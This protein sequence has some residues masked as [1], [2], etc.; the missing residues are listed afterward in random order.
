MFFSFPLYLKRDISVQL[1]ETLERLKIWL[2]RGSMVI[3]ILFLIGFSIV[4]PIDCIAQA[5]QSSNN[6]LNTFI[7]VGALVA[8]GIVCTT[9]VVARILFH[10]SC[11]QDIPRRYIPIAPGDLPHRGSR[12]LIIKNMDKSKELSILFKKPK[13]PV[14]HAG[15]EPPVRC[16]SPETEK[17]F[18]EYLNYKVCIKSLAD[19]LK[20]QGVFL[21]NMD[22][23]MK[24][25]DTFADVVRNQFIKDVNNKVQLENASR[26]IELYEN[27]RFSGEE[28]TREQF[29]E[30]VSLAIY[31]VDI[32]LT[33]DKKLPRLGKL[34]TRSQL[35]FNF[36]DD[37]WDK[38]FSKIPTANSINPIQ[39]MALNDQDSE[40]YYP[41]SAT[42]LKRTNTNSTVARRVSSRVMS[43]GEYDEDREKEKKNASEAPFHKYRSV[44]TI[45]ESRKTVTNK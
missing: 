12:K 28:V 29:T 25:D 1:M 17:L 37:T 13:D 19:R 11:I 39:N 5:S 41:D 4:L 26:F 6:A 22:V 44:N 40:L 27:V 23:D 34:N 45:A 35:Q 36:D 20:Y 14:I 38:E 18:P 15:L 31:F 9:I 32:S 33:R 10:K 24:L 43:T 7:V 16:D 30:F 42:Y 2:Y 8:F 21:N 3:A